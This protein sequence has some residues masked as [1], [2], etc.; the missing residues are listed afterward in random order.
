MPPARVILG[1]QCRSIASYEVTKKSE[2]THDTPAPVP[3]SRRPSRNFIHR[4]R[5]PAS[6]P[7][8]HASTHPM[9]P[10]HLPVFRP[11]GVLWLVVQP[12]HPRHPVAERVAGEGVRI[13]ETEKKG[14]ASASTV[15]VEKRRTGVGGGGGLQISRKQRTR[16]GAS[17]AHG[18][19][20]PPVLSLRVILR[21]PP[22]PRLRTP[23]GE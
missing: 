8:S 21:R 2:S 10:T 20:A 18:R 14:V 12:V 6:R 23:R 5:L 13:M 19:A 17:R 7:P 4:T 11:S 3:P 9:H 22:P 1:Y 16:R 15:V